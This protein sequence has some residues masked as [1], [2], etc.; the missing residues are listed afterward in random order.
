MISTISAEVHMSISVKLK[1]YLDDRGVAY[2][3]RVHPAAYTSQEI[4]AAAHIP[5]KELAKTVIV[6]A[7][8]QLVMAVLPAKYTIDFEALQKEIESKTL[9]LATEEEF[10]NS[11]P[12]CDVGAMPPFGNI[13]GVPLYCDTALEEDDEIEFNA[14]SHQDTIRMKFADFKRLV[15]PRLINFAWQRTRR[16]AG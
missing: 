5:G 10:R 6:K 11:F 14:G 4:A 9:R 12:T 8:D 3:H 15:N 13:F 2:K 16:L 1:E 7:D